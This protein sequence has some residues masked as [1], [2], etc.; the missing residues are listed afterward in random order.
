M[1][2]AVCIKR[3]GPSERLSGGQRKRKCLS[4]DVT[5]ARSLAPAVNLSNRIATSG[6]LVTVFDADKT[7]YNN[8]KHG[9]GPV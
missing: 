1:Y 6:L 5:L 4:S 8:N 9:N 7:F 2:S 3:K